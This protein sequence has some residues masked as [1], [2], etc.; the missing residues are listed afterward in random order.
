MC[1]GFGGLLLK[2]LV[3]ATFLNICEFDKAQYPIKKVRM[4][5]PA[6]KS[7][8]SAFNLPSYFG[9]YLK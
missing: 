1:S 9:G 6:S 7:S 3:G 4:G 8:A 2:I 5:A